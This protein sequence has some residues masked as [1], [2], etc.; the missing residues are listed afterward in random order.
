MP[1]DLI[2]RT[3]RSTHT[4]VQEPLL[5]VASSSVAALARASRQRLF[6]QFFLK[7][8]DIEALVEFLK[9]D[10]VSTG[11]QP[12]DVIADERAHQPSEPLSKMLQS[13]LQTLERNR[14]GQ[15]SVESRSQRGLNI[16]ITPIATDRDA[17]Q[18]LFQVQ[19]SRALYEF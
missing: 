14:L 17:V 5:L 15:V 10:E 1:F 6:D 2:A 16:R 11:E 8:L 19:G 3:L 4:A 12:H 13:R 7:P 9:S 18:R